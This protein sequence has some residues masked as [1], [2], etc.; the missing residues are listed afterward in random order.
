M[1]EPN[2]RRGRIISVFTPLQHGRFRAR[3]AL[4]QAFER[5]IDARATTVQSIVLFEFFILDRRCYR[6]CIEP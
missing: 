2:G 6:R 1:E 4:K 5:L 3:H